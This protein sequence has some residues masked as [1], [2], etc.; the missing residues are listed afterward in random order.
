MDLKANL[1]NKKVA[2]GF[3]PLIKETLMT[4]PDTKEDENG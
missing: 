3:F 1:V 4:V 2:V